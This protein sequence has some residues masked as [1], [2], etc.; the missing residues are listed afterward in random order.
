M[1]GQRFVTRVNI[2]HGTLLGLATVLALAGCSAAARVEVTPLRGQTE[3]QVETDRAKC[4]EWGKKTAVVTA[5]YAACMILAGYE[6]PPG[7]R[8]TS[9]RV[10]L[11]RQPTPND[12]IV[13]LVD[14]LVCDSLATR[15][16]ESG[17][18]TVRKALR[19]YVGWS[20]ASSDKRQQSF[21]ACLRPRGYEIG[22]K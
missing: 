5:G 19:D 22:K 16:A 10:R 8:A 14:F 1:L 18:G 3:S 20:L 11:A 9:E 12:P 7:V 6:A 13:I 17:F 21:I 15:E 2:C 4:S